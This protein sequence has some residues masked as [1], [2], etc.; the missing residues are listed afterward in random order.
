M[1]KVA[2]S[3]DTES[4]EL[5][6]AYDRFN[7]V[8]MVQRASIIAFEMLPASPVAAQ[9]VS[10]ALRIRAGVEPA[11]TGQLADNEAEA[12]LESMLEEQKRGYE[13]IRGAALTAACGAFEYLVQAAFVSQAAADPGEAAKRFADSKIKLLASDVLGTSEREQWY[14]I[15]DELFEH[16]G[17]THKS[18][19]KRVENYLIGYTYLFE[20]EKDAARIRRDFEALD[21]RSFDEAF[22]VRNCLVHNG[23]RVSSQLAKHSGRLMGQP[24][25]FDKAMLGRLLKPIRDIAGLLNGLWI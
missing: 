19:C 23:G 8:L 11:L 21:G 14:A 6:R 1:D 22:L 2:L 4:E 3:L 7:A 5:S 25:E 12:M 10:A 15:A 18:M 17:K 13:V 16:A 20:P 9:L 24:I